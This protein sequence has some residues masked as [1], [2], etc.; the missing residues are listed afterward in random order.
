MSRKVTAN[1][2][3]IGSVIEYKS[4]L[5]KV[6]KKSHVKPGKGPA[7]VQC[8]LKGLNSGTKL[9]ERFR[10]TEDI[11]RVEVYEKKCQYLYS[12]KDDIVLMNKESYDQFS[13]PLDLLGDQMAYL[14]DEMEI[15]ICE[16]G[17]KIMSAL[18][19]AKLPVKV[20][21]TEPYIKGQTATA[22]YKPA[23]LEKG[24]KTSVPHFVKTGD[25]IIVNTEDHSYDSRA[26]DSESSV[27]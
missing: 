26:S 22:S 21:Y 12:E 6:I 27:S 14:R 24:I 25:V 3:N 18:V 10:A 19:P 11:T 15:I 9:N 7:Y 8:E 20:E 16:A 4:N 17:E 2:L 23:T 13:I 1:Q 5:Y